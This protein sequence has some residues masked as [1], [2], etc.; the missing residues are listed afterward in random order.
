MP[1]RP[2]KKVLSD[3]GCIGRQPNVLCP[4][5]RHGWGD[6][7][8]AAGFSLAGGFAVFENT[9]QPALQTPWAQRRPA[10]RLRWIDSTELKL[11]WLVATRAPSQKL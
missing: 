8:K 3:R 7:S 11:D 4:H 5:V 1:S 2:D 10:S 9:K 6:E